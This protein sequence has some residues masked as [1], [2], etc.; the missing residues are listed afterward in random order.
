[1]LPKFEFYQD[2][3]IGILDVVL[4]G[5]NS[6][7]ES[8]FIQKIF[9]AGKQVERSIA[10]F[11]FPYIDRGEKKS[12]DDPREEEISALKIVLE[13]LGSDRY[14]KVRLIGKS[15][16]AVVAAEYLSSLDKDEQKKF[17]LVVLGYDLGWIK[18]SGFSGKVMIIQG[19]EDEFGDID[20]V[21]KDL[22][23][24]VFEKLILHG[25]GGADHSFRNPK[26]GEP[27]YVNKVLKLLYTD[28]KIEKEETNRD[29][30][31]WSEVKPVTQTSDY[32]CGPAA[33]SSILMLAHREEVL[34]TDIYKRLKV[35][36]DGTKP[37]NI[38]RLLKEEKIEFVETF[39]ASMAA[40]QRALKH[41]YVCLVAYQM[42]GTDEEYASLDG[43]HYSVVFDV[44]EKYVWLMDSSI[45]EQEV[46]EF[47]MGINRLTQEEF[48][49]KWIDKDIDG[50]LYDHWMLAVRT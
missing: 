2:D 25:V 47:G 7:I 1:M 16:G 17:E 13:E 46:Y 11:N 8:P 35:D 50:E 4:H 36:S 32:D 39:G 34:K 23:G 40:L 12:L 48:D 26:T 31:H 45:R 30:K 21:R 29:A 42:W 9:E 43:G 18:L 14:Q 22:R 19:S 37:T 38:K 33:V 44:D 6:G 41:G 10:I 27:E 28:Y 20:D 15:L 24:A 3:T 5:S 49:E